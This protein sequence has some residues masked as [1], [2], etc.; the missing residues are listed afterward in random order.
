MMT[1]TD[2]QEDVCFEGVINSVYYLVEYG[3]ISEDYPSFSSCETL[4]PP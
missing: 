3:L 1:L 2:C 4:S